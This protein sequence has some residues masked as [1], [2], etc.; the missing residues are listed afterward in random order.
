MP[1][2]VYLAEC[3]D[4]TLYC[5]IAK[6]VKK[7]IEQHNKGEGARYTRP[8]RPVKLVYCEKKASRG[9]ALKREAEIKK[10]SRKE[11]EGLA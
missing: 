5:G 7:R 8:R 1:Y 9:E 2:F 11:K 4:K 10:M 6:D 3:I